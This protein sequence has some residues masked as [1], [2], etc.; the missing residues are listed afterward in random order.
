MTDFLDDMLDCLKTMNEDEGN[1][2]HMKIMEEEG[3]LWGVLW[4]QYKP[5]S[6]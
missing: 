1:I 5:S 4:M 2:F 3:A 6:V